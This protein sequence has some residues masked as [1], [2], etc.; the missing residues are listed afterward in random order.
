MIGVIENTYHTQT[1][2][3]SEYD[4]HSIEKLYQTYLVALILDPVFFDEPHHVQDDRR[5]THPNQANKCR[6]I[7]LEIS[8]MPV[9]PVNSNFTLPKDEK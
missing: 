7:S 2:W 5:L 6:E 9:L 4:S 8:T 1:Q 3:E